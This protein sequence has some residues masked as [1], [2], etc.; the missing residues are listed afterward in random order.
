MGLACARRGIRKP[1]PDIYG[2]VTLRD[3]GSAT[4]VPPNE[5]RQRLDLCDR[6]SAI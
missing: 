1:S 2:R 6:D 3:C 4:R 5:E